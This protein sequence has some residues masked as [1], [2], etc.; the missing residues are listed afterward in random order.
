MW[1]RTEGSL[2]A[3]SATVVL[4]ERSWSFIFGCARPLGSACT[5]QP[6]ET[7]A[8]L[9]WRCPHW[10]RP[11]FGTW[12][13]TP[14]AENRSKVGCKSFHPFNSLPF[15]AGP[16]GGMWVRPGPDVREVDE[17]SQ[18]GVVTTRMIV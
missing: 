17:S 10:D 8:Q 6:S 18:D 5:Y 9:L 4:L 11:L 2:V 14:Q 13:G 12:L 16:H 3:S 7:H 1:P 15:L